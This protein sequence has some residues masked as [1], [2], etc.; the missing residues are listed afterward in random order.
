MLL[1][2]TEKRT[3]LALSRNTLAGALAGDPES[4]LKE[5]VRETP[6]L[7]DAL[8]E[9]L[10]C[11][12]TLTQKAHRLRGCIGCTATYQSLYKNVWEFTQSAAFQDPRF[13]PVEP[14]ELPD[15]RIEISVLGPMQPLVSREDLKIGH[16]GL[17]V[18]GKGR[19]GLLLAQVAREWKWSKEEFLKQTCI[20]AN[21]PPEDLD[22]YEV[23]YFEQIEFAEAD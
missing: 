3:L 21:L 1:S 18:R 9:P 23:S 11:F 8:L 4:A 16:H 20:K 17:L 10:P 7:T 19:H 22:Q 6:Q 13:P 5:F 14:K 12:V 2:E 15:L